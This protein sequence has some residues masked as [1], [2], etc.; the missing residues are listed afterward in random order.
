[1]NKYQEIFKNFDFTGNNND[2]IDKVN[3]ILQK[4]TAGNFTASILKSI[5]GC[6]DLTSLSALDSEES[7]WKLVER[8]NQFDGK[9]PD[10][11]NVA[12][13]CTYPNFTQTVKKNLTAQ[14]VKIAVV[15]GGFPSSQTFEEIK[16]AET[17]LAV[18]YGAE[19]IDTVLNPGYFLNED[20]EELITEL[21]E[22]KES[23]HGA[24]L[25]IIIETGAL[26]TINNIVKAAIIS[27]YAGADFI[28]TS[29][30]KEFKGASFEAVY[31]MCNVI[32]QFYENRN[33]KIGIKISGG[34]RKAEDAV[35]YYTIVKSVLGN[36]WLTKDLF[37]IGASSLA[38]DLITQINRLQ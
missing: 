6:I 15:T 5:H 22:I 10:I 28:K 31:A 17:G 36:E 2:A 25:K 9:H 23:A 4:E 27:I 29:T 30:G 38:E 32:K 19:E 24:T 14:G 13:I 1:M 8:V 20:Y 35:K 7:I 16:V 26:S 34:V 12:A 33:I 21:Q 37:R 18:M 3:D 11:P